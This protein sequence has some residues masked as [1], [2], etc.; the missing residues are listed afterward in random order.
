M[1]PRDVLFFLVLILILPTESKR[2]LKVLVYSPNVGYSHMQFQGTLA[3]LLVE[4]GHEVVSRARRPVLFQ[5]VG[6]LISENFV[7]VPQ[8]ARNFL[9]CD[10]KMI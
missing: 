8:S 7:V 10:Y 1:I 9:I 4:A 3:D 6:A 5:F 2:K